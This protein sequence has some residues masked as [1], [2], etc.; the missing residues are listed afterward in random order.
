MTER[1]RVA[2]AGGPRVGKSTLAQQLTQAF[3]AIQIFEGDST[4]EMEWSAAS[5]KVSTWFDRPDSWIIEGVVVGR[6]L[7]KWLD[8]RTERPC[9]VAVFLDEPFVTLSK[10]QE[11]MRKGCVTVWQGIRAKLIARGVEVVDIGLKGSRDNGTLCELVCNAIVRDQTQ[12]EV[13]GV[14]QSGAPIL[15]QRDVTDDMMGGLVRVVEHSADSDASARLVAVPQGWG[16]VCDPDD[17]DICK[18]HGEGMVPG[19]SDCFAARRAKIA[20][21]NAEAS[22]RGLVSYHDR[23]ARGSVSYMDGIAGENTKE[24]QYDAKQCSSNTAH[25]STGHDGLEMSGVFEKIRRVAGAAVDR[26]VRAVT[27]PELVDERIDELKVDMAR[28]T[29]ADF[30]HITLVPALYFDA[31][32]NGPDHLFIEPR[33]VVIDQDDPMLSLM[34]RAAGMVQRAPVGAGFAMREPQVRALHSMLGDWLNPQVAIHEPRTIDCDDGRG[35]H[36]CRVIDCDKPV[37]FVVA[38][39]RDAPTSREVYV[40]CD[41]LTSTGLTCEASDG[42]H[43]SMWRVLSVSPCLHSAAWQCPRCAKLY[44]IACGHIVAMDHRSVDM[45]RKALCFGCTP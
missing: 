24:P 14:V 43:P 7:R 30:K 23:R 41:H 2:I 12:R 27:L 35:E 8:A 15:A 4:K 33:T 36:R 21:V 38:A 19:L 26:G 28:T 37:R 16:D 25:I 34:L 29:F 22:A 40:C 31:N 17:R 44:C 11:T 9:D 13:A 42:D 18:T 45:E 1:I 20:M 5:A 39:T 10:G 32:G 6:A 3:N